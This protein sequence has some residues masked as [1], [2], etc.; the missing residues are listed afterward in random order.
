MNCCELFLWDDELAVAMNECTKSD[1]G[2][3]KKCDVALVRL[4]LTEK[5]L[6]RTKKKIAIMQKKNFQMKMALWFCWIL[7]AVVYKFM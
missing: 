5:K 3:C 4:E 7:L 2:E 6:E 1:I